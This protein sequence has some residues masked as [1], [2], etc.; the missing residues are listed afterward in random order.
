MFW[1]SFL[2]P[3][4]SWCGVYVRTWTVIEEE[5]KGEMK[6]NKIPKIHHQVVRLALL[7]RSIDRLLT[8]SST[9][10]DLWIYV[11]GFQL[12]KEPSHSSPDSWWRWSSS[13]SWLFLKK[14]V[15]LVTVIKFDLLLYL[16]Y[17]CTIQCLRN[18]LQLEHFCTEKSAVIPSHNRFSL[19]W[20]H[21]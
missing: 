3:N 17:A 12:R 21:L 14:S 1:A 8:S 15:L 4:H 20:S 5:G 11:Y 9:F 2:E 7:T 6:N 16:Y 10:I 13:K 18:G 19:G